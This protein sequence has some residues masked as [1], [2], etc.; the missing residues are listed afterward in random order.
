MYIYIFQMLR[1]YEIFFAHMGMAI[2]YKLHLQKKTKRKC[3][4]PWLK[5]ANHSVQ[6]DSPLAFWVFPRSLSHSFHLRVDPVVRLQR[7]PSSS[8][9]CTSVATEIDPTCRKKS[10]KK[11]FGPPLQILGVWYSIHIYIIW[12]FPKKGYPKMDG[13]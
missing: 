1:F 13:L 6:D 8:C 11:I 5:Y 7:V 9:I 10:R 4:S 2:C 3:Q 12:V